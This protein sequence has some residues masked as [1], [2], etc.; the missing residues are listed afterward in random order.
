MRLFGMSLVCLRAGGGGFFLRRPPPSSRL[1]GVSP[2]TQLRKQRGVATVWLRCVAD[3]VVRHGRAGPVVTTDKIE[4]EQRVVQR[5]I[6]LLHAEQLDVEDQRRVGGDDRRV[7]SG[8]VRVVGRA[9]QL[10]P[11]PD[12]HLHHALVPALDHLAEADLEGRPSVPSASRRDAEAHLEL[13]LLA[14][15]PGRVELVACVRDRVPAGG[16][17]EAPPSHRDAEGGGDGRAAAAPRPAG[18]GRRPENHRGDARGRRRR[19]CR[20]SRRGPGGHGHGALPHRSSAP[21]L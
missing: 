8:A 15:V 20:R 9:R 5:V 1:R 17:H 10:G 2:P 7:A 18:G 4:K 3:P 19:A 6:S 13:E 16:V 11:L 21:F 12:G 14:A